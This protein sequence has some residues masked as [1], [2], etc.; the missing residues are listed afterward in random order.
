[1]LTRFA[2]EPTQAQLK[3]DLIFEA[4]VLDWVTVYNRYAYLTPD[5]KIRYFQYKLLNY[6]LPTNSV[7]KKWGLPISDIC[8][9]CNCPVETLDHLFI[10][11][12]VVKHFWY[13]I[14]KFTRVT[15]T[16]Y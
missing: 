12:P 16:L 13:V 7:Y 8:V 14:K 15:L 4:P 6:V 5:P 1:M 11:W 3:C 2:K 9:F 10:N